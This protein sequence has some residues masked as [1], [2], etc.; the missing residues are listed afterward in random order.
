[1][2]DLV[3][4]GERD[5]AL[6]NILNTIDGIDTKTKPIV[7]I[8]TTNHPEK[9]SRG[10]LRAGRIDT[11]IHMGA[12]DAK[13]AERFVHLYATVNGKSLLEDGIDLTPVG[14]ELGGS[15]PSF[16]AEAV[17]KAKRNAI[18]RH[19]AEIAGHVS[20]NDLIMAARALKDHMN[21]AELHVEP[22]TSEKFMGAALEVFKIVDEKLSDQVGK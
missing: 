22:T 13:T 21:M 6:N 10:F 5:E 9:I 20:Q 4:T 8:L 7:T 3:V 11:I 16:I 19:G 2:I 17:Q 12:P 18:H 15:P 1:M 14:M